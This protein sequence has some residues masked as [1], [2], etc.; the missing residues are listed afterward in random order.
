MKQCLN[1]SAISEDDVER[2]VDCR[3]PFTHYRPV[4]G[5]PQSAKPQSAEMPNQSAGWLSPVGWVLIS[6]GLL[7]VLYGLFASGAPEHSETLN[8][9]LLND[10]TNMVIAGG[11]SFT[12]GSI[13]LAIRAILNEMV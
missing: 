1:C 13:F 5:K 10:K 7:M 8:I 11:F 12:S 4:P 9:G 2:C 6:I 3:V